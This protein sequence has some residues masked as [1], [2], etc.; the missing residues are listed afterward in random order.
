MPDH[1]V[2]QL[3]LDGTPFVRVRL[4]LLEVVEVGHVH[5]GLGGELDRL[6]LSLLLT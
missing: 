5:S 3:E 2:G 4:G 1:G 6:W